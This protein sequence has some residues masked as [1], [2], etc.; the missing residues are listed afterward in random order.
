MVHMLSYEGSKIG[1]FRPH[2]ASI[3]DIKIDEDGDFV[4]TASVEGARNIHRFLTC[5]RA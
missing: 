4:A 2:A 3:N 1:S 5:S